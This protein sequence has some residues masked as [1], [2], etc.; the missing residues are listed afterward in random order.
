[1]VDSPKEGALPSSEPETQQRVKDAT[2]S[3]GSAALTTLVS[4]REPF[5]AAE[6]PTLSSPAS[7]PRP[8]RIMELEHRIQ[9]LESHVEAMERELGEVYGATEHL[10][11]SNESLQRKLQQQRHGRYIMWGTL[12]AIL[13][14]LWVTLRSRLGVLGP[15]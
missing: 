1:M 8:T 12:I 7:E 15:G 11:R 14:M 13:V 6:P 9:A 3:P 2:S 5:A 4:S 10:V